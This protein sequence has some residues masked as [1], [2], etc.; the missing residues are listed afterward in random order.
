MQDS[1]VRDGPPSVLP[2]TGQGLKRA[3]AHIRRHILPTTVAGGVLVA[4]L[5]FGIFSF[6]LWEERTDTLEHARQQGNNLALVAERDIQRNFELFGLS[7]QGVVENWGRPEVMALPE[8]LRRGVL[9]DRSIDAS[10]VTSAVVLDAQGK[11]VVNLKNANVGQDLSDRPYFQSHLNRPDEGLHITAPFL[12]RVD[13]KTTNIALSRRL[14]GPG[15]SFAGVVVLYLNVNYFRDLLQGLEIGPNGRTTVF[16]PHGTVFMSL[17]YAPE[18]IGKDREDTPL[19]QTVAAAR[20]GSFLTPS[21]VDGQERLIVFRTVTG[22]GGIKVLVSPATADIYA[23]WRRRALPIAI[24]VAAFGLGLI[25]L[26]TLL[27]RELQARLRAEGQL[28][29]LANTDGLTGLSN[30][31]AL[32]RILAHE[33]RRAQRGVKGL[34][35]L[36]AD[37]DYFKRYNDSQGHPAGDAVLAAVADALSRTVQRP[38]DHVGRYGGEEFMAVLAQTDFEGARAVAEKVRQAVEALAIPH[39]ASPMKVV[40]VSIGVAAMWQG[41]FAD[42]QALVKAADA[43]LYDAK[44]AGRNQVHPLPKAPLPPD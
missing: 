38:G 29:V 21:V 8:D 32:E 39:P 3:T 10:N 40:T 31:R 19:Y 4:C 25:A 17:P 20:S 6:T 1:P 30:R 9:F 12:S 35:V 15:G 26:S 13:G 41:H 34:G 7:L 11:V 33:A 43:A 24:A 28:V 14:F 22:A 42:V 44:A 16:G 23:P 37:V 18:L 27:G 5:M 2:G 36:F